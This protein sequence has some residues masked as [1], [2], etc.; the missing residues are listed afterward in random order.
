MKYCKELE[1]VKEIVF[2]DVVEGVVIELVVVNVEIVE[3]L[4]EMVYDEVY[5]VMNEFM[6][7]M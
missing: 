1:L 7:N 5:C 3:L 4:E 6:G 2:D